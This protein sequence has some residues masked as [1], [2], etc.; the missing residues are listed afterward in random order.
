MNL[1]ECLK[2][3]NIE[4]PGPSPLQLPFAAGVVSGNL[5]FLS[6][7]TPT[8]DG[9]PQYKGIVGSTVSVEEAQKAAEVCT[10]NLLAALRDLTGLDRI[11]RVVKVNGYVASD[12]AFTG[13][14]Q[15][16]NAATTMLN[17]IFGEAL[18]HARAAVGVAALPGGVSVEI[19][20]VVELE[21]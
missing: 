18:P 16:I 12:P 5:V 13:Q 2:E 19:E 7:Q 20:M 8:V 14:P 17:G 21:D 6:G 11:K 3:L 15:V 1:T 4:L 10:L 9:V